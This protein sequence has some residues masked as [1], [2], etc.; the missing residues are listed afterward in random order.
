MSLRIRYVS[1]NTD[2][3]NELVSRQAFQGTD[4]S[5]K[6]HLFTMDNSF[7]VHDA[8]DKPVTGGKGKSLHSVK[9]KA[10]KALK[11][12]GV[13]FGSETRTKAMDSPATEP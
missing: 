3:D 7:E 10:K 5:Y 2:T 4:S 6:V 13:N 9:V 1:K 12:L 11:D 8:S